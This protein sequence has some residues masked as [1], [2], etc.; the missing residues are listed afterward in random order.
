MTSF[1][2]VGGH[3][4]EGNGKCSSSTGMTEWMYI[5]IAMHIP[6][7]RQSFL[8]NICFCNSSNIEEVLLTYESGYT[9]EFPN[10][11]FFERR[12]SWPWQNHCARGTEHPLW[13]SLTS[14]SLS[15]WIQPV[16]SGIKMCL[17]VNLKKW[18]DHHIVEKNI[19]MIFY[20]IVG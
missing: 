9:G 2:R 18:L 20:Y 5:A 16:T 12:Q 11:L 6:Q 17:F 14:N 13:K 10:K 8:V 1:L 7:L 19:L 3:D 4:N 15:T